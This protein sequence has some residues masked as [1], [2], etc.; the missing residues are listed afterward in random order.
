M[1]LVDKWLKQYNL[2]WEDLSPEEHESLLKKLKTVETSELTV[3]DVRQVVE[4]MKTIV[5]M[6]LATHEVTNST[7][8]I[9]LKARLKNYLILLAFLSKTKNPKE[10]LERTL[11][12]IGHSKGT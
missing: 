5:E 4:E 7:Q 10:E 9:F 2:K 3:D 6:E 11:A 1:N 8:D 12:S